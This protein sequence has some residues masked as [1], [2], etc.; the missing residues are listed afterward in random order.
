MPQQAARGTYQVK[1]YVWNGWTGEA[2]EPL[3]A[4]TEGSFVLE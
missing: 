3:S 2:V 1:A 4:T